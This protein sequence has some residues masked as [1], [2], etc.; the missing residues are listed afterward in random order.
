MADTSWTDDR[1]RLDSNDLVNFRENI[2]YVDV[3]KA[4]DA[5]H[6]GSLG[7]Y[8]EVARGKIEGY[9]AFG[10][11][12]NRVISDFDNFFRTLHRSIERSGHE[13]KNLEEARRSL[14]EITNRLERMKDYKLQ[15]KAG[16]YTFVQELKY[17]HKDMQILRESL[18]D[19]KHVPKKMIVGVDKVFNSLLNFSELLMRFTSAKAKPSH[20][21]E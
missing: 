11:K 17:V 4:A 3:L 9:E 12:S 14:F 7:L 2:S 16:T 1:A 20:S 21:S 13:S 18:D 10:R 19:E 6:F 5:A 8:N 15:T